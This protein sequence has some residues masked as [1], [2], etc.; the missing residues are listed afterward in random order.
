MRH[1]ADAIEEALAALPEETRARILGASR[2]AKQ[3]RYVWI[4]PDRR[5]PEPARC[6]AYARS[7]GQPCRMRPV[8]GR[9]RCPLHGGLSTGPKTEEGRAAIAASNRRRTR[10]R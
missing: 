6:G 7:T 4:N 9:K 8:P 3:V 10:P 2:R 5:R 1:P